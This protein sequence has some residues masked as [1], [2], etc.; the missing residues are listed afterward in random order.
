MPTRILENMTFLYF[1]RNVSSV[2]GREIQQKPD[3]LIFSFPD[4][5]FASLLSIFEMLNSLIVK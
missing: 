1:P 2:I 3:S 5:Y 4:V